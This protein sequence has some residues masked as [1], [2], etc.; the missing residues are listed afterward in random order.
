MSAKQDG[1]IKSGCGGRGETR[2]R[3][4]TALVGQLIVFETLAALSYTFMLRGKWPEPMTLLGIGLLL[5][6]VIRA[7]R[8]KPEPVVTEGHAN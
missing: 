6:G 5:A 3:L 1:E 7:V 8:I 2:R 4:P